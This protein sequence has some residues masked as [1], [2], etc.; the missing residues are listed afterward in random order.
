MTISVALISGQNNIEAE[1][2]LGLDEYFISE[3][4]FNF[5][6]GVTF[7]EDNN[8]TLARISSQEEFDILKNN[9]SRVDILWLGLRRLPAVIDATDPLNFDF[10]DGFNNDKSFFNTRKE[11]PW[12]IQEPNNSRGNQECVRWLQNANRWDDSFCTNAN[13]VLCR[14]TIV[15]NEERDEIKDIYLNLGFL[16]IFFVLILLLCFICKRR[17]VQNLKKQES[18]IDSKIFMS[19]TELT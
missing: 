2:K 7:C 8:S 3:T 17:N 19:V 11:F 1:V 15:N 13:Q 5:S 16:C 9:F 6:N 14:R 10:V 18:I 4:S 12:D